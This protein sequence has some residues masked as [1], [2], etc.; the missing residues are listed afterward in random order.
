MY[1]AELN[2][3]INSL[4]RHGYGKALS[5]SHVVFGACTESRQLHI[6]CRRQSMCHIWRFYLTLN[7]EDSPLEAMLHNIAPNEACRNNFFF[8][9]V[10]KME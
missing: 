7:Y 2:L 1:V 6:M 5:C 8:R 9:V 4:G 10:D 3:F